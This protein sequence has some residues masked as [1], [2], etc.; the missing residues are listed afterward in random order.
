M[1]IVLTPRAQQ[2][3]IDAVIERVTRL[4]CDTLPI[5]GTER[6]VLAVLGNADFDPA[7]LRGMPGVVQ[8]LRVGRP[9][10]LASREVRSD[11]TL[12]RAG[13]VTI[14]GEQVVVMAGPPVVED[15]ASLLDAARQCAAEGITVL[16]GGAFHPRNSP[17]AFGGLG[18][19]ALEILAEARAETGMQIITEVMDPDKVELVASYADILQIGARNMQN[20]PLLRAV[21]ELSKPVMLKRGLAAT[22]DEL[23]QAAE[24]ILAAG[25]NQQVI[26]CERGIRTFGRATRATLDLAA[27][28]VLR[29]RTHLPIIV[30][31]SHG[32]GVRSYV[33]P[34]ARAAVAAG[35][36]GVIVEVH[37][38][39]QTALAEGY[40]SLDFAELRHLVRD[41]QTIAPVVGRRLDLATTRPAPL[42]VWPDAP[43]AHCAYQGEPGA[44]S[45]KAA[46]QVFGMETTCLPCSSFRSTFEAV[47]NGSAPY[48]IVPVEN[49]LGGII[50]QVWDLLLETDL[51]VVAEHKLRV[52][53]NLIANRGARLEDIRRIYAH[54]QAAA[55]CDRVLRQHPE[56][57]VY[58]VYDTA[59]AALMIKNENAMD[60]AAIA[61]EQVAGQYDMVLLQQGIE[62]HPEN[63][64]RF[65]VIAKNAQP[66]THPTKTTLVYVV[67]D[68]P[69]TLMAS[70]AVFSSRGLNLH[71]LESRPIAG[72]PWVYRFFVDV[73]GVVDDEALA[74]LARYTTELKLIGRYP[75]A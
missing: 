75:S 9:Y 4:G 57:T 6:S 54:P 39:P 68:Q 73:Q 67:A 53:H 62:S 46:R 8:V 66:A 44:F 10:K 14:G 19:E 23:L 24:Y 32:T 45:E 13:P 16:R 69:G 31:P 47:A 12:V 71:K 58:Q 43:K 74:E 55:Q 61:G 70:L 52:V 22:I 40:Q 7:E 64:T 15:R 56:W 35:C 21:A 33:A 51:S 38:A 48:G 59:G 25:K 37:R 26:L 65:V 28:C 50:P 34:M 2:R 1:I 72:R 3:E 41:L 42:E 63:Y 18:Q 36:D 29:E 30:D 20:F 60:G 5:G 11:P 27:I 49:T 17:Y